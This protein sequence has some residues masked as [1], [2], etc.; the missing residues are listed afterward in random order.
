MPLDEYLSKQLLESIKITD[1]PTVG[2]TYAV[3]YLVN[4]KKMKAVDVTRKLKSLVKE[5]S[6]EFPILTEFFEYY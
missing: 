2:L 1:Q 5:I 4:E 6:F 3:S